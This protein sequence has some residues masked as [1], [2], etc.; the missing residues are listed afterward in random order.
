M[1]E[2]IFI[3]YSRSDSSKFAIKLYNFL[4]RHGFHPWLDKRNIHPGFIWSEETDIAIRTCW[5][6]VFIAT[7]ESVRSRTCTAEWSRA[8]TFK[9]PIVPLIYK[10]TL[11]PLLLEQREYISLL[12]SAEK[13]MAELL[14]YLKFLQTPEGEIR[15]LQSR[16]DDFA[17]E[18]GHHR[19]SKRI[20]LEMARLKKQISFKK[21]AADSPQLLESK[22]KKELE[23]GIET[24]RE[25][26][27][28]ERSVDHAVPRR[29]VIGTPPVGT[30]KHFKD[31]EP[32][33]TQILNAL[34]SSD[35]FCLVSIY[36]KAGIGKTA[37]A[38]RAMEQLEKARENVFGLAY[39]STQNH[40]LSL[41]QIYF[42]CARILG[43]SAEKSLGR[44][45]QS[46]IKVELKIKNL[47]EFCHD[48]RIIILLDNLESLQ[49][50]DGGFID[51]DLELFIN[52]FLQLP[53]SPRILLTSREPLR[54]PLEFRKYEKIIPLEQ[55]LPI[56]N[57]VD[58]L[59]EL[60]KD[61]NLEKVPVSVLR[62]AAKQAFG[63]PRA[64]EAIVGLL[65]QDPKLSL[66]D[67]LDNRKL[68][69]AKVTENLVIEAHSRLTSDSERVMQAL[70]VFER[71]TNAVAI[72][73]LL[74]PYAATLDVDATLARLARGYFVTLNRKTNEYVLH[75]LDQEY[76][77][78]L[79]P[80]DPRKLYNLNALELR[81]A[82]YFTLL[83]T[84]PQT[85]FT[86]A[87]LEPQ[88]LAFQHLCK[89]HEFDAAAR[90]ID[91]IDSKYLSRWGYLTRVTKMRQQ[92]V[93]RI[94]E[95]PLRCT[96]FA[97]LGEAFRM[98]GQADK[99]IYYGQRG[100]A[101]AIELNDASLENVCLGYLGR[102]FRT[103]GR[104]EEAVQYLEQAL[105]IA[106]KIGDRAS[107]GRH[108][109]N[110]GSA[111]YNL[112]ELQASIDTLTQSIAINQGI[113]QKSEE[114]ERWGHLGNP[115][116]YLGKYSKA[117]ELYD[118][119]LSISRELRQRRGEGYWLWVSGRAYVSAGY[120]EQG[121]D[122]LQ[123]AAEIAKEIDDY[124]LEC[125][126]LGFLA[127]T[128]LHMNQLVQ[129]FTTIDKAAKHDVPELNANVAA[130]RGIILARLGN[131]QEA[132]L[133]LQRAI[134]LSS[135]LL[136]RTKRFFE[137][138]YT[139]GMSFATLALLNQTARNRNTNLEKASQA[140]VDAINNCSGA[141]VLSRNLKILDELRFLDSSGRLQRIYDLFP[142]V[143]MD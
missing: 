79:I 113:G 21:R 31:R 7:P 37:L 77:Y 32:E 80:R 90:L 121:I 19:H 67:L 85:W 29:R 110:L 78:S 55:G 104:V 128:Y 134:Q 92:L 23:V 58:L 100:L 71:P 137:A 64:L 102:T 74:E 97:A 28:R 125:F 43:G 95:K 70:A 59:M 68:F 62:K 136:K 5:L 20:R 117:I 44:I 140:Y 66:Q 88:L 106:R 105:T 89:A 129:A 75:P 45:W 133:S 98:L 99:A 119:A 108:L 81:A 41:E 131:S 130:I 127:E 109:G 14:K 35:E 13:G 52:E 30:N 138:K 10:E 22:Y 46:S 83:Q 50:A 103:I 27:A 87:D 54:V 38:C 76:S 96:N 126:A 69:G 40:N 33:M 72:K 51:R 114:G 60:G 91:T 141:G 6:L 143:S 48:H 124:R 56:S 118:N 94:T 39:H 9:K 42:S 26:F 120:N 139:R 4:S 63:Y 135:T 112:G 132:I 16:Y 84:P 57:A 107:E 86:I 17:L 12:E 1:S 34:V 11:L 47:L 73:Y 24:E 18:L 36:G 8:L 2:H 61:G 53:R 15:I 123:R 49:S 25:R 116:F 115:Y 111:Y 65:D 3:S 93:N 122:R 142:S 101:V 82:N